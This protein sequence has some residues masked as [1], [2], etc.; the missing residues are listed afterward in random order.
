M[1][2]FQKMLALLASGATMLSVSVAWGNI[3]FAQILADFLSL[4]FS[5]IVALFFGGQPQTM[6][7]PPV[8]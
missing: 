4:V 1:L 3:D 7:G 2:R 8:A 5:T 6:M